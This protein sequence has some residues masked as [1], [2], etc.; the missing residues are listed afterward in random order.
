MRTLTATTPM[1]GVPRASRRRA[2]RGFR[3]CAVAALFVA[4]VVD[5]GEKDGVEQASKE[6]DAASSTSPAATEVEPGDTPSE[7]GDDILV[8]IPAECLLPEDPGSCDETEAR[9]R[10]DEATGKCVTFEYGGC[11]RNDNSF[12]SK[13]I[14]EQY[15]AELLICRCEQADCETDR[16]QSCPLG[17]SGLLEGD[18]AP[19]STHGLFCSADQTSCTCE[20]SDG[21]A[22]VWECRTRAR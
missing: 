8:S 18:G 10:F 22:L 14:C 9:Y 20:A 2:T 6:A 11:G 17:E 5:E 7:P 3:L 1:D 19:C 4:C 15:C 16:C 13:L 21:G 12:L